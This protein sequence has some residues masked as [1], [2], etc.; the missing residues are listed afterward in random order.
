[1]ADLSAIARLLI[2]AGL[3]LV[4]AGVLLLLVGRIPGLGWLGRLPGDITFRRGPVTIFAPIVTSLL[5]SLVL[6]L[7][8]N[9]IFRR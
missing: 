9:L 5:V 6:T 2:V 3:V 4:G 8:L 7:I 1:M